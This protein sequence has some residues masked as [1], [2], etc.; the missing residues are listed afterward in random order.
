MSG[1]RVVG[2][3]MRELPF[4]FYHLGYFSLCRAALKKK[5]KIRAAP[6]PA[7]GFGLCPPPSPPDILVLP[8]GLVLVSS[9]GLKLLPSIIWAHLEALGRGMRISKQDLLHKA[10]CRRSGQDHL[11]DLGCW[12]LHPPVACIFIDR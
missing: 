2:K 5:R 11:G 9:I 7:A 12:R 8:G 10:V 1:L 4:I 6:T 3:V